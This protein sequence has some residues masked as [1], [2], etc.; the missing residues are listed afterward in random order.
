MR[1]L[2]A[3]ALW[4]MLTGAIIIFFYLLKLKRKRRV[5]PSVL[6]WQRALEEVEANA[7]FKK[8]RR[9]LLLLLQLAALAA[10]AFALARPL[11]S[12]RSLASGNTVIIIDSTASMSAR[13]EDGRSRLDRAKELARDMVNGLSGDDA[14]AIIESSSRVTV[15]S[16]LT[17]DRAAL[18]SAINEAQETDAPGNLTDAVRLAE[19]IAKTGRD[20][21]IVVI[22]D[23]GGPPLASDLGSASGSG[24][25]SAP[26]GIGLR[27]VRVG[28]RADNVGIVA[29]NSRAA[30]AGARRELFASIANFSDGDQTIGVELKI[31]GRLTDART[32]NVAANDRASLVFDSLPQSGGLAELKLNRG[33]DLASDNVAYA[34]LNDARR[35]RVGVASDNPFL[36]EAVASNPDFDARKINSNT[37]L[38][39]FDCFITDG[40]PPPGVVESN[41]PLLAVNP[42]DV[43]GLWRATGAQQRT[44]ITS[45]ERSHPVN[46]FLSYADLRIES[47]PTRE[48]TSWLRPVA[49]GADGGLIW[50]GDDGHRR[51]VMI[52]FDL[53]QSDLPLKVEFPILLANSVTWL[54]GRDF[55]SAERVV[56]AGQP[57]VIRTT[58]ASATITKPNGENEEAVARDGSII[59]ADTLGVGAYEV[60]DAPTFAASLLSEAETNTAPRDS[61]KTR[62][63]EVGGQVETFKSEREAWRW[64]A[65]VVLAVLTFEWWVYHR[66][67]A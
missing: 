4:W 35:I 1:L 24:E 63:G 61:I 34:F 54:A 12:L 17:S 59:F 10:L 23:G 64:V 16:S 39:E 6:L 26:P 55:A 40:A 47:A 52:G 25:Q 60:K 3:S 58:A 57:A 50:A 46:S 21:G 19:Q 8:L 49:A 28:R 15:R 38:S 32:V 66:R 9:S 14:A 45:V 56:R 33:D 20:A 67:I 44:E 48:V 31:D 41:R 53:A 62:A 29:M 7:P 42:S 2:S 27:F 51:V 36:L 43:Q 18:L 11:I 65:L 22:S 37:A 5:V 13:D 30:Q